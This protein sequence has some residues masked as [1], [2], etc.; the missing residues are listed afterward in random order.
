MPAD[1]AAVLADPPLSDLIRF[2]P[3]AGEHQPF[4]FDRE[5]RLLWRDGVEVPLPPRVLGVLLLLLTRPG[6]VVS[7]Q[8]LISAVWRDA[9]VTETSLA[10]AVSVLR[11]ALADDPQHPTFVQT[12]HRRG[13]RLIA[14]VQTAGVSAVPQQPRAEAAPAAAVVETAPSL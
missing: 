12:L 6:Q 13:Y 9:F 10:E 1:R 5:S 8:E 14:S 4:V 3:S 7:K 2:G 11:Q